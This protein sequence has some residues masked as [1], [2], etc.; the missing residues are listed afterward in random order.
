MPEPVEPRRN[1]RR[2]TLSA[3][4]IALTGGVLVLVGAGFSTSVAG[5]AIRVHRPW[6]L[7]GAGVVLAGLGVL[8]GG[9]ARVK[10]DLEAAWDAREA[11][12]PWLAGGAAVLALIIGLACGTLIRAEKMI[13]RI[14]APAD[15]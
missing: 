13:M 4:A 7:L 9:L 11:C 14:I 10:A 6:G 3:A 2:L 15:R 1:A 12:A 5:A 8:L